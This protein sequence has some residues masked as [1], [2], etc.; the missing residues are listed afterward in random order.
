MI[1]EELWERMCSLQMHYDGSSEKDPEHIEYL[2][3][4]LQSTLSKEP[5]FFVNT[6]RRNL[7][8]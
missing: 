2:S 6:Q 7:V 4:A 3:K 1:W 8:G 5:T